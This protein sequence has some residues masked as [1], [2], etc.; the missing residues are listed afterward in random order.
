MK[1]EKLPKKPQN[2]PQA[3]GWL[4][5]TAP[6]ASTTECTGLI[7]TPPANPAEADSYTKLYDIPMEVRRQQRN[8]QSEKT[9]NPDTGRQI[10]KRK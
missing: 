9:T 6:V 3:E 5:E 1:P 8:L 7:P 10:Q 2:R 4:D